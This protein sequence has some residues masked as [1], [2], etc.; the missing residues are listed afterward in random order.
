MCGAQDERRSYSRGPNDGYY[1][2]KAK[3]WSN[4]II[5]S[6][7]G[8]R[9]RRIRHINGHLV[10]N[11]TS[12]GKY[13]DVTYEKLLEILNLI[14]DDVTGKDFDLK[15]ADNLGQMWLV[16]DFVLWKYLPLLIEC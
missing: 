9:D 1:L 2:K 3:Y 13:S 5:Q 16:T 6:E 15:M 4:A 10:S 8:D 11:A 12:T 14:V 7:Y